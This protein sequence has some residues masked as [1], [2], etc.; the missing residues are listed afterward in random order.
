MTPKSSAKRICRL[1]IPMLSVLS[2]AG[3]SKSPTENGAPSVLPDSVLQERLAKDEGFKSGKDSP[4]PE[5]DKPGFRGLAYYPLN[6]GLRFS[7]RL[8]RYPGPKQ[9]RMGTNTGEIRRGLRYGYF[10]FPVESRTCRLQVYRLDD[11]LGNGATLFMPFRDATS[12]QETYASGRYIEL[13]ENT[14]G[15]YDLDFNRAFNPY[16]AYNSE[17]SC[18]VPPAENILKVPI[19]A[20]EKNYNSPDTH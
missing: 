7:A 9:V 8:Y 2:F 1:L 12:G 4:I 19:R 11:G 6:P 17:F 16:C 13:K 14:S 10:E 3:C 15:V 5:R 20:G 18:P